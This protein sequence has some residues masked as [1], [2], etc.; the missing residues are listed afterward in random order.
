MTLRAVHECML[1]CIADGTFVF[2]FLENRILFS[3]LIVL[4]RIII[5]SFDYLK[6]LQCLSD[7]G[8]IER[9]DNAE[10]YCSYT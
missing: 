2:V 8:S 1:I 7:E 9:K 10:I 3:D 5:R 4:Y 6:L